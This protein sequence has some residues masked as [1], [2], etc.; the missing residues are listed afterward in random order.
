MFDITSTLP[1]KFQIHL[2]S[3]NIET[4]TFSGSSP[5]RSTLTYAVFSVSRSH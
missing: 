4:I 3:K 1:T 5:Y 2:K